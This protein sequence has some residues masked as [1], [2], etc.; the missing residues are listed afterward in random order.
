MEDE[1]EK[2][3]LT[4][5]MLEREDKFPVYFPSADAK[6]TPYATKKSDVYNPTQYPIFISNKESQYPSLTNVESSS[7]S[8]QP[9]NHEDLEYS[10]S[11][12]LGNRIL[13]ESKVV[14]IS[15]T[16]SSTFEMETPPPINLFSPP[17][18][19][20]GTFGKQQNKIYTIDIQKFS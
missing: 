4:Y 1:S 20:E 12:S 17:V 16:A 6:R 19:T 13:E 5:P 15:P 18:E 8:E 7:I 9:Y 14:T 2:E 10:V 3:T 11:T